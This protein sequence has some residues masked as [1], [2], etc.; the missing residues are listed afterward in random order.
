MKSNEIS[1][2]N[3][4]QVKSYDDQIQC[5]TF[6]KNLSIQILRWQL[7]KGSFK[8]K[9]LAENAL[10]PIICTIP[11]FLPTVHRYPFF[12]KDAI[13]LIVLL[14]FSGFLNPLSPV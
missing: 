1:M 8:S 7:G 12:R 4:Q 2:Q 11:T 10:N 9:F 3:A 13:D 6:P 5:I 14:L